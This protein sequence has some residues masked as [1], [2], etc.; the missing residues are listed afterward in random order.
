[1]KTFEDIIELFKEYLEIDGCV[2]IVELKHG[3]QIFVWDE[4]AGEYYFEEKLIHTPEEL[5]SKLIKEMELFGKIK[6]KNKD[7]KFLENYQVAYE[8]LLK[9]I[10]RR[11]DV[12]KTK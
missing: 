2:E 8:Q 3:Y 9:R 10:K 4:I 11:Y 12:E 7:E 1:M 5:Y 6:Y